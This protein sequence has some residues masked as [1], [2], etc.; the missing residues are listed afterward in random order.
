MEENNVRVRVG[1]TDIH[2]ENEDNNVNQD[3]PNLPQ[4]VQAPQV[5]VPA[6]PGAPQTTLAFKVE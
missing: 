3:T 2:V 1:P 5:V 4:N 6:A